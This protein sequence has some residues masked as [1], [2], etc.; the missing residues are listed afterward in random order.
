MFIWDAVMAITIPWA[1]AARL[2]MNTG[3]GRVCEYVGHGG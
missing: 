1:V 2:E 3:V